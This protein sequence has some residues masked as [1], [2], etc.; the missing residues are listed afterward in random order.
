MRRAFLL[1]LAAAALAW[2]V[3][4]PAAKVSSQSSAA[5]T[6]SLQVSGLRAPVTVRRD[7]RS[8]P[9][10]E[11]TNDEDLYF[12]Q[13]YVTASDRLWQM[14]LQR[15]TA[16]GELSEIFGQATLAQDRLHRTFGFGRMIDQAAA[17]LNPKFSVAV[18]AYAKGVNAYINSLT[19]QTMPPEFRL[20]QYKPRPWAPADSLAV[21]ALMAEYLSSTWQLDLMRASLASLPKEKR[22]ALLPETSPLDVLVVGSDRRQAQTISPAVRAGVSPAILAELH[23]LCEAQQR[24]FELLGLTPPAVETIHASN[25]WVVSGKRTVTGKPMLAN[26]PHIPASAPGIWYQTQLSAPGMHVA[27]VTFPGAPGIVAGHNEHIAWGVTNLGPDV[28][29]LYIEKFDKANPTKYQTPTGLRDAEVRQEEIKVRKGFGSPETETQTFKVTVT[30]HGPI[31]L[32]KDDTRYALR[33]TSLDPSTLQTVGFLEVNGARNWKEFTAALSRYR[34]PTQNFVYA[35]VDG[36]IGYYGAGWIPIRK[37]GDGSVPY[38]GATDEGEWTG[39]IPFEK[40]PHLYDPPSGI[41]VTANQRVVGSSYPYFVSHAWAT[42]YRARR[43]A[44]LLSA[45]PKLTTDDFRKVLGDVHSIGGVMFARGAAKILRSAGGSASAGNLPPSL[46]ADLESWDGAMSADS[47]MALVVWQMRRAFR[48]RII[49]AALGPDLARTYAWP[50]ADLLADRAVTEQ[51]REW[52]PKE[53]GSYAELLKASYEDARQALTKSLGADESK[54]SWGAQTKAR[55]TH[56]LAAAPLIG[57]QFTIAPIPQNGSGGTVNVGSA[58]SMRLIA[59][60]S[61]WDKSQHGIPLGQSGWPNSPHWKDQLDDWR[62]V[63]PRAFPFSKAAIASAT[64]DT[65]VLTPK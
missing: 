32:E 39:Y 22:E 6:R 17:N 63:T 18:T 15:R 64:K 61:D 60:T 3:L 47:R 36:H 49:N 24:S 62:N 12:A 48:D 59:D 29:D 58:V 1:S 23:K 7:D 21:G 20:L 57:A 38:D 43:I 25:N 50:Q 9:Y 8:I 42:P 26:D 65:V 55:F 30:R 14:D 27:G 41:I 16:R 51:P 35:D 45:K 4:T 53:F 10:I 40:L 52:L 44:D 11:A 33:W 5:A 28:Q 13:G 56:P 54:W 2:C 19:D 46:I 34:G 31:V 37:S